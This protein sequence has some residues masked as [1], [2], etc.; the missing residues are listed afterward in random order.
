MAEPQLSGISITAPSGAATVRILDYKHG[1]YIKPFPTPPGPVTFTED[2]NFADYIP[3]AFA[4]ASTI[5]AEERTMLSGLK[6]R[7]TRTISY[8]NQTV[9]VEVYNREAR[10]ALLNDH[11]A[12][13]DDAPSQGVALAFLRVYPDGTA[14]AGALAVEGMNGDGDPDAQFGYDTEFSFSNV[15][16]LDVAQPATP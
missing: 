11:R 6:T 13:W 1:F 12:D 8:D 3:G 16:P 10:H 9:R 5:E 2:D 14:V 15:Y 7:G 4:L